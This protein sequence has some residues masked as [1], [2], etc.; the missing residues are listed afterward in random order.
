MEFEERNPFE[1]GN[2]AGMWIVVTANL[3]FTLFLR[4]IF[5]PKAIIY[6]KN[7][8]LGVYA[9]FCIVSL[10]RAVYRLAKCSLIF[11]TTCTFMHIYLQSCFYWITR[12]LLSPLLVMELS[13]CF[14]YSR[15][16]KYHWLPCLC[17]DRSF[18]VVSAGDWDQRNLL[19]HCCTVIIKT[20]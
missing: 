6:R 3:N 16:C 5:S 9:V 14:L 19:S 1:A 12:R 15:E 13:H 8:I 4:C 2:V 11:W 18:R 20:V 17:S 7:V 10:S